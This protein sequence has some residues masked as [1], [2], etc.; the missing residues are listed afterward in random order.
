MPFYPRSTNVI[1][2]DDV[3]LN[4]GVRAKPYDIPYRELIAQ[5]VSRLLKCAGYPF[6]IPTNSPQVSSGRIVLYCFS[7]RFRV[8]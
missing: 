8:D 2:F 1:V 3:V 7:A 4:D 5:V 6:A